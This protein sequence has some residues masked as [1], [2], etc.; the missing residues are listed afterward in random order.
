MSGKQSER[1]SHRLRRRD[2]WLWFGVALVLSA[3]AAVAV[4]VI[5]AKQRAQS[6]AGAA[7]VPTT[8][9]RKAGQAAG[10][11]KGFS[12]RTIDG[13]TF[14]LAAARGKVVVVD[15][16]APGCPSCARDLPGLGEAARRFAPRG[17][18]VVIADMSGANDGKAL[19]DYYR[20]SY[21]VPAVVLIAEDKGFRV[22]RAYGVNQLGMTF[23][24]GRDGRIR[25]KGVWSGDTGMLFPAVEGASA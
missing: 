23:V 13:T 9:A 12:L 7:A 17:V 6:A 11:A 3:V 22:Q 25:W 21:D 8:A 5:V 15:F 2:R 20:G 10:L 19:R 14:S 16:L 18:K 1:R 24:I 4:L